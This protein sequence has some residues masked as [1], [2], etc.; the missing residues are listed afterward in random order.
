MTA[1]E[2]YAALK[3]APNRTPFGF[4]E[5]AVL[6]NVDLQNAYTQVGR[7][8]TAYENHPEQIPM[9]NRLAHSVRR[10][11]WPVVWTYLA[12]DKSG[13]D[14]GVWGKRSN[15]ADSLQNIKHGSPRAQMDERLEID[16]DEDLLLIKKMPSAF[17]GTNL[18]SFLNWHRIDTV[19]VTGGSTSGCV[20]ATVV[21][22]LSNGF[23][24]IVAEEC[25]ADVHESPHYANLY[26]M[27]AKYADVMAVGEIQAWLQEQSGS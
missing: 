10:L 16:S 8:P 25:V 22:S 11:H 15:T 2:L 24:T 12:Y 23:R 1:R 14:C 19:I 27:Q 9:V 3:I 13:S 4:G 18:F 6:I 21:D 7:Y 17:H 20:R 5:K 26:D